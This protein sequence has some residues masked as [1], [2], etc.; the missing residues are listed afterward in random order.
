MS[1]EEKERKIHAGMA[2]IFF[3]TSQIFL[4]PLPGAFIHDDVFLPVFHPIGRCPLKIQFWNA[5]DVVA[6]AMFRELRMEQEV[7]KVCECFDWISG[8]FG[9]H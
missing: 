9:Y 6:R 1:V 8:Y 4:S 2:A 7:Q 3:C 5:V